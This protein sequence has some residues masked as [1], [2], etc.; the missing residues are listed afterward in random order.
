M[1][2]RLPGA[3]MG[4]VVYLRQTA[5]VCL[6][7]VYH[8]QR[9]VT[10]LEST[11]VEVFILNSL[12]PFRINTC[13]AKPHFAHFWCN[14]TPFRINTCKSVTKQ[15]TLSTFRINTYEKT[16]GRGGLLT[17]RLWTPSGRSHR[18]IHIAVDLLAGISLALIAALQVLKVILENFRARLAQAFSRSFVQCRF[19]PLLGRTVRMLAELHDSIVSAP[20]VLILPLALSRDLLLQGIDQKIV[21]PQDKNDPCDP[22][23]GQPLEHGAQPTA[24]AM[25]SLADDSLRQAASNDRPGQVIT[26]FR[27]GRFSGLMRGQRGRKTFLG[28]VFVEVQELRG[29]L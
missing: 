19:G 2:P 29:A 12:N 25:F 16:G 4:H 22:K 1:C 15:T 20:I 8:E 13:R 3:S 28:G 5:D 9:R 21:G 11:L 14:V 17:D 23:N 10:P 26:K 7:S 6:P 27:L 24:S 18:F